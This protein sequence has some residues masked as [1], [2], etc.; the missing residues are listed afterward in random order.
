LVGQL[1]LLGP[2]L[3]SA[4]LTNKQ[5]RLIARATIEARDAEEVVG[6]SSWLIERLQE[7]HEAALAR[8][9]D[10]IDS[11]LNNTSL[12]LL[13]EIDKKKV[14]LP[15]DAQ[16]ENWSWALDYAP[17][18]KAWRA[19]LQ[20]IDLYKVGHHGSRNATPRAL[21]D[22]WANRGRELSSMMSTLAAKHHGSAAKRTEF[23]RTTLIS[24]L[25]RL[26][27]LVST[28]IDAPPLSFAFSG[29]ATSRQPFVAV[30]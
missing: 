24:A 14:L 26:G 11:A 16:G 19:L 30:M 15:G 6:P 4:G 2:A 28:D 21:Y 9:V 22:L 29:D 5:V 25:E 7:R 18:R 10:V 12:I 1:A 13:L 23:P 3:T 17:T 8:V 20:E 27:T